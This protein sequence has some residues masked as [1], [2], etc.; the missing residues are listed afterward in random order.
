LVTI[1]GPVLSSTVAAQAAAS[2]A[3][4]SRGLII[5]L[6]LIF[7]P[8]GLIHRWGFVKAYWKLWP[9]SHQDLEQRG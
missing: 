2:L 4:I 5:I 7:E 8:R 3:L 1:V 6:F 9:F